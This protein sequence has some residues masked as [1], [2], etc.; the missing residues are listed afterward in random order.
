MISVIFF[1]FFLE[2]RSGKISILIWWKQEGW[3][4]K[5]I[6]WNP[7]RLF[8]EISFRQQS[9][10]ATKGMLVKFMQWGHMAYQHQPQLRKSLWDVDDN[11]KWMNEKVKRE[12]DNGEISLESI[13][14]TMS[15]I[16]IPRPLKSVQAAR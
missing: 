3:S 4:I 9:R 14:G 12:V 11:S 2:W 16:P 8:S 6:F 7:L 15:W 13:W 1:F 10:G 5:L